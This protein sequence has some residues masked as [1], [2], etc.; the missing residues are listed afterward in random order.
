MRPSIDP[1]VVHS[2][3]WRRCALRTAV[4]ALGFLVALLLVGA[5]TGPVLARSPFDGIPQSMDA[6]E[7][8]ELRIP[9]VGIDAFVQPVGLE[10]DG[11][12]GIPSN[13]DDVAWFAS[14]YK[15]GEEGRA[16]FDGHVSST[17]AAAVFYYVEDL[18]QN[19]RIYVTDQDGS[20]LTFQVTEVDSYPVDGTPMDTIFGSSDWPQVVLITCGGQWHPDAQLF[21]HRTVVF[22]SLV[23]PASP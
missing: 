13:F 23:A 4:Q 7:P 15:P 16:V 12:M 8:V 14:G 3:L 20:V 17:D 10:A 1:R 22:A 18:P 21:D 19:S 9:A 5:R 2:P 11:S 6:A